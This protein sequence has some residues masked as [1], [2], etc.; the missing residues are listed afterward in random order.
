MLNIFQYLVIILT[1][2]FLY[3][4]KSLCEYKYEIKYSLIPQNKPQNFFSD[5]F[6]NPLTSLSFKFEEHNYNCRDTIN[7]TN[8]YNKVI[9]LNC[10]INGKQMFYQ[11]TNIKEIIFDLNNNTIS[12]ANQM[13]DSCTELETIHLNNVI[14]TSISNVSYMFNKCK[15]LKVLSINGIN[16]IIVNNMEY[17]FNFCENLA[18]IDLTIFDTHN[19]ESMEGIFSNCEK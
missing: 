10:Q 2:I 4:P 3:L 17:M 19:V 5:S 15:K 11:L 12:Q 7:V 8:Y 1:I 13:F 6:C 14:D 16:S 18:S 9:E